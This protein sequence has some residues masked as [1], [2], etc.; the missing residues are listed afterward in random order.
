MDLIKLIDLGTSS[1][2]SRERRAY[3]GASNIG[4][5]CKAALQYSLRGYPQKEPPAP[6]LRIFEIGHLIEDL[7]VKDLQQAGVNVLPVNTDTGQQWE[8]TAFSGHL[9][10]HADGLILTKEGYEILE[11]K[12]M[13]D[14]KWQKFKTQGIRISHPI[15]FDQMQILMG[16]AKLKTAWMVS[17]N[18]DNSLYHAER[19]SFDQ[20]RYTELLIKALSVVRGPSTERI[21]NTPSCF[22]CSYCNYKPHC[23]PQGE[24]PL[25]IPVECRTCKHAKPTGKRTWF[26]TLHG[27]RA[28]D[29]CPQWYKVE[30]STATG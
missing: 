17:Y 4:N 14:R 21:S 27:S 2:T 11:I 29:P 10:G 6:V 5:P 23:W 1:N 24:T 3:I 8:Y 26:C 22:E 12:S 30:S 9:R 28:T 13:K 20:Y 16:L 25:P 18:K 19:V 15:Y 7:V